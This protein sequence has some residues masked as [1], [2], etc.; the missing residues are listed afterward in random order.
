MYLS[1]ESTSGLFA[2]RLLWWLNP[3]FRLGFEGVLRD[4]DLFVVDGELSSEACEN[5]LRKY[6]GN[7]LTS[8]SPDGFARES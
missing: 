2:R 5:R 8:T 7:R 4:Q 3:L 6:W 1:P